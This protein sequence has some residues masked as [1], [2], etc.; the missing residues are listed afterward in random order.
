[1]QRVLRLK[2]V[3]LNLEDLSLGVVIHRQ[4]LQAKV[5]NHQQVA[6]LNPGVFQIHQ[7]HHPDP[8]LGAQEV[9]KV[10][11]VPTPKTMTAVQKKVIFLFRYLSPG[12]LTIITDP[13]MAVLEVDISDPHTLSPV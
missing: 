1:M 13:A 3:A 5:L 7:S 9:Q 6:V 2:A 10:L 11:P 4:N 8:L 12:V